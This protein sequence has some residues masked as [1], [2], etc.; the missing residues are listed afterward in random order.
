LEDDDLRIVELDERVGEQPGGTQLLRTRRRRLHVVEEPVPPQVEQLHRHR[1]ERRVRAATAG[2]AGLRWPGQP[3]TPASVRLSWKPGYFAHKADIYF[4]TTPYSPLVARDI[5]VTPNTTGYYTLPTLAAG[6]TYYW[7]IV[8]KTMANK[9]KS[10]PIWS[11]G[12]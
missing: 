2:N 5:A 9:T 6:R 7:R 1:R 8:S 12:T 4:G 11:F 10:G 3:V